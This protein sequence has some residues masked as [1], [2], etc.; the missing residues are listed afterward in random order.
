MTLSSPYEQSLPPPQLKLRS[1]SIP[2]PHWWLSLEALQVN[3]SVSKLGQELLNNKYVNINNI[4]IFIYL[5]SI[6]TSLGLFL[7]FSFMNV[8]DGM[9]TVANWSNAKYNR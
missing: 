8:W 5:L 3:M 6:I 4:H 7:G 9:A 2:G 1:L